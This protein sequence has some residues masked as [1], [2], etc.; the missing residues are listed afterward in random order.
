MISIRQLSLDRGGFRLE[1]VDLEIPEGAYA[2]LMG[3][4]GCGKTS[5]LECVAGLVA[6]RSGSILIGGREV[7]RLP[8]AERQ[9][10][11]VPQDGA[12]FAGLGVWENLAFALRIRGE[13]E[14]NV[15]ARITGLAQA[16]G[17]DHLLERGIRGLSGGERQRVALG[18]ALAFRPRVLLLDEPLAALDETS[19]D[20]MCSLLETLHRETGTTFLHVTHSAAEANRLAT[21]RLD[22]VELFQRR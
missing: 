20:A 13:K 15:K 1:G 12:L 8:A 7:T 16:L 2:V 22:A 4:T 10:G 3:P 21:V 6:A 18:R 9:L 11:Y 17:I 5:V 19:R 14:A